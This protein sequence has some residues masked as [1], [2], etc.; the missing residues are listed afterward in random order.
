MTRD[1]CLR[2]AMWARE[3]ARRVVVAGDYRS[4]GGWLCLDEMFVA[5]MAYTEPAAPTAKEIP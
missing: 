1:T 5:A 4:A 2:G 3:A